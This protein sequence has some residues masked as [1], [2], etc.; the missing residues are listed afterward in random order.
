MKNARQA[1]ILEIIEEFEIG[2]QDALIAKLAEYGIKATQTTVSRDIR[3]LKLIKG[4]TGMG[5]YKYVAP[6]AHTPQV[7]P[8]HNSALTAAV[9]S[10]ESAQNIVV[11]KT[12]SGM[13]NAVAL[14]IDHLG[15]SGMLGSVAG[16]D[17]VII[18]VRDNAT[19]ESFCDTLATAFEKYDN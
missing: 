9:V 7:A 8:I 2:T 4:P 5:T 14:C 12:H 19:S 17:T 15:L 3:E 13:A 10:I 18:V 1:K 16:D 11:V 6:K